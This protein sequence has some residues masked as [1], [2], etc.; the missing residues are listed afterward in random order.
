M[1]A[2]IRTSDRFGARFLA[3]LDDDM[4]TSGAVSVLFDL[5]NGTSTAI[6]RGAASRAAAFLHE[7]LA[8]I[9]LSPA[10]RAHVPAPPPA[11]VATVA[12]AE[13]HEFTI[14]APADADVRLPD[15]TVE[16]LKALVP[17]ESVYLNG[18]SKVAAVTAVI[19]ARLLAKRR[20]DFG[21][22]DVMRDALKAIGVTVTDRKEGA[23]WIVAA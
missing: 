3:A 5:A 12:N 16:R 8:I 21:L 2:S 9:G 15:D 22:A 4:N 13:G 1:R 14:L 10:A 20:R 17:A 11:S 18:H 19:E 7:A 6:A 23:S